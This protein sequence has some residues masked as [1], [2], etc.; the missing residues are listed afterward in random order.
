M[1]SFVGGSLSRFAMSGCL[2][3]VVVGGSWMEPC[4]EEESNPQA[5]GRNFTVYFLEL[6]R[7]VKT[8]TVHQ[9][10]AIVVLCGNHVPQP[11]KAYLDC[12]RESLWSRTSRKPPPASARSYVPQLS[13]WSG[14]MAD[15]GPHEL[16]KMSWS[17]SRRLT[18][19]GPHQ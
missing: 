19:T 1:G 9:R 16:R 8:A 10:A 18:A 17:I 14:A 5:M 11:C 12:I 4:S 15:C 3:L 6:T 7:Q 13:T 2:L